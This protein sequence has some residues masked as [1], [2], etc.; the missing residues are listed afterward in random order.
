MIQRTYLTGAGAPTRIEVPGDLRGWV[1]SHVVSSEV[2]VDVY[3]TPE[4]VPRLAVIFGE[5][6]PEHP[7]EVEEGAVAVIAEPP[8]LCLRFNAPAPKVSR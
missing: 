2:G 1:I 7:E 4:R 6:D 5:C 3:L 8:T